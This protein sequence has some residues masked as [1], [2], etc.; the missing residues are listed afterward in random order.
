MAVGQGVGM[1]V[2]VGHGDD[3]ALGLAVEAAGSR[4]NRGDIGD[5]GGNGDMRR[6]K[7]RR[8]AR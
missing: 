3:V 2:V 6:K 4:N 5:I 8:R 7:K 1:E